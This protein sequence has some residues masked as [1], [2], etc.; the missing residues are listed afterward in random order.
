LTQKDGNALRF[1]ALFDLHIQKYRCKLCLKV[2]SHP[3]VGGHHPQHAAHS[4]SA[5]SV[6]TFTALTEAQWPAIRPPRE[7]WPDGTDWRNL[8]EQAGRH[9]WEWQA[10]RKMWL[11]TELRGKPARERKKE[12]DG[13]LGLTRQLQKAW[14]DSGSSRSRP[15]VARAAS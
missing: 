2:T 10:E 15:Q 12:V 8:I 3:P 13:V 4:A 7:N 6:A 1:S 14:A 11:S 9:F 5:T